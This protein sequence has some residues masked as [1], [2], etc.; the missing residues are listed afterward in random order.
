MSLRTNKGFTLI[1]LLVVI[2]IIG[3]LAGIILAALGTSRSKGNDGAAQSEMD[4]IKTQAEV[5]YITN[6]VAPNSYGATGL[7]GVAVCPTSGSSMFAASS[8]SGGLAGLISAVNL[9][10]ASTTAVTCAAGE[11]PAGG[12]AATSWAVSTTLTTFS[13]KYFCVDSSGYSGL[14][15]KKATGGYTAVAS[16]Q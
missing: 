15:T 7:V 14:G 16:C 3:I 6:T 12:T 8:T 4:Q 10:E 11:P 13:G 9:N 1:E 5:Y 2:A